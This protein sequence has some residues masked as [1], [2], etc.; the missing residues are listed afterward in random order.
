MCPVGPTGYGSSPYQTLSAFAGNPL[1]V[2]LDGLVHDG[3]LP[4]S[5]LSFSGVH[6]LR[7]DFAAVEAFKRPRF[8]DAFDRF[9]RARGDRGEAYQEFRHDNRAWLDDFSPISSA[10]A[11][12][13]RAARG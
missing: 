5:A 11:L 12:P 8:R 2:S 7:V 6:R 10:Q 4:K 3:W 1:F 9:R 13:Q